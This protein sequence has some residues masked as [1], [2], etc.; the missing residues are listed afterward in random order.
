MP[1]ALVQSASVPGTSLSYGGNVTQ[2]NLLIVVAGDATAN[3]AV[4]FSIAD[5]QVNTYTPLLPVSGGVAGGIGQ[6]F[7]ATAKATGANTVTNTVVAGAPQLLIHEFSVVTQ[8]DKSHSA[9][10][11]GNA[12]DSGS[13][14]TAVPAEL[15]FGFCINVISGGLSLVPGAGW[16]QAQILGLNAM[17]EYQVVAATGT[18]NATMTTTVSKGGLNNWLA[19]IATFS[20]PVVA[21]TGDY[22]L[23]GRQHDTKIILPG[24]AN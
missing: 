6:L 4:A 19:Q 11:A 14:S 10:G 22:W 8:I 13:V 5:S 17:T 3:S 7:Y 20:G 15:L 9:S 1:I 23:G 2:G 24:Y 18:F 21:Q 16:T 12:V